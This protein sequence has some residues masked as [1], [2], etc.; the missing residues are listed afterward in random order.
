VRFLLENFDVLS[1]N[2]YKK[3]L[4]ELLDESYNQQI[5]NYLQGGK[6][7]SSLSKHICKISWQYMDQPPKDTVYKALLDSAKKHNILVAGLN[8]DAGLHFSLISKVVAEDELYSRLISTH[9]DSSKIVVLMGGLH[10]PTLPKSSSVFLLTDTD[11]ESISKQL[12]LFAEDS[13]VQKF[14]APLATFLSQ[15]QKKGFYRVDNYPFA[16]YIYLR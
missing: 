12:E 2:G 15:Q 13:L 5:I 9:L 16:D 3:I 4:C 7:D 6:L 10:S 8:Q 11:L 14:Y 1:K